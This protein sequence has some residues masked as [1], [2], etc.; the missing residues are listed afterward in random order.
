VAERSVPADWTARLAT[1]IA[2]AV[3]YFA[4]QRLQGKRV[5]VFDIGCFPWHGSI[6]LS[7]LTSEELDGDSHLLEPSELASWSHYNFGAGLASW[8]IEKILG[9]QMSEAYYLSA[10]GDKKA[11]AELFLQACAAAADSPQVRTAIELFE[12]DPKFK[13]RVAHPDNNREFYTPGITK[14][15]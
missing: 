8:P 1:T 15:A 6:E 4:T 5:V 2:G 9:P 7:V 13:I 11:I 14:E 12:R 10:D 3:R